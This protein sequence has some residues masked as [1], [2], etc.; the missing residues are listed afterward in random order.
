M[1]LQRC[2][3]CD[4]VVSEKDATETPPKEILL[5]RYGKTAFT[6]GGERG[7]FLFN[8]QDANTVIAEFNGRGRDLVIDFE[9]QS[10]SGDKAPAA[11]WIQELLKTKDGLLAKVKYWTEEAAQLIQKGE[12]RYFSPTLYFSRSGKTISAIHSVALTNHPAMHNVPALAASDSDSADAD[13]SGPHSSLNTQQKDDPMNE[14]L[15]LTGLQELSD[16]PESEQK[17]ALLEKLNVWK[18]SES[19]LNHFLSTHK[20]NDL[21]AASQHLANSCSLEEKNRLEQELRSLQAKGL[22][23]KAFADGKIAEVNRT[24]ANDFA[25]R[26]PQEFQAWAD[27]A[28]VSIPDNKHLEEAGITDSPTEFSEKEREIMRILGLTPERLKQANSKGK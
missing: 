27:A 16:R 14:L 24:W 7:E 17:K 10:L 22:V 9:H 5:L 6:K 4:S 21:E 11:G 20:F 15:T 26:N 23:E 12:Y 28:P 3:L 18:D 8:E 2:A 25:R 19:R 1:Q 13:L